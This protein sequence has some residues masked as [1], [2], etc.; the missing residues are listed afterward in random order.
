MASTWYEVYLIKFNIPD[1]MKD[2]HMPPDRKHHA[3]FVQTKLDGTGHMYHVIG[4]VAT[5]DGMRYEGRPDYNPRLSLNFHS[6]EL[7]GYTPT[8]AV[9]DRWDSVL[10]ALLTP[11]LQKAF[12]PER[13][14]LPEPFKERKGSEFVFYADGETHKPMWKCN[15]W[16]DWYAKPALMSNELLRTC[17]L[18]AEPATE[19]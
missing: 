12:N 2:P 8:S 7:M 18:I 13:G 17:T 16:V 11:P 5:G 10:S 4:S 19:K 14:G 9:P 6:K 1:R 3:I 15:E